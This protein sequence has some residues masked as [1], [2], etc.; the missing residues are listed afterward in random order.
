MDANNTLFEYEPKL[1]ERSIRLVKKF[2]N[3]KQYSELKAK[4]ADIDEEIAALN[5]EYKRK[6]RNLKEA[7]YNIENFAIPEARN[8]YIKNYAVNNE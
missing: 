2:M 5:R 3:S 6:L 8:E 4:L 1:L 7:K